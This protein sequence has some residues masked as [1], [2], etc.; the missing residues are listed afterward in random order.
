MRLQ[1]NLLLGALLALGTQ[2][3]VAQEVEYET[4]SRIHLPGALGKM[5]NLAA[6]LGGGSS[7][8]TQTVR[9]K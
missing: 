6:K 7:E 9:I 8:I 2:T 3:A 5:V 4:A 1:R